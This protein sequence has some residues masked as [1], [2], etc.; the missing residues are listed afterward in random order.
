METKLVA[1]FSLRAETFEKPFRGSQDEQGSLKTARGAKTWQ[2]L[3]FW[4]IPIAF[5]AKYFLKKIE[6]VIK[7]LTMSPD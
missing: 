6:Y 5:L 2:T 1:S 4:K 3:E 7:D